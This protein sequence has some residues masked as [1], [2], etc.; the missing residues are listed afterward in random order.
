MTD[1]GIERDFSMQDFEKQQSQI[2]SR[3][4]SVNLGASPI[5][6]YFLPNGRTTD[7]I[8]ANK[9]LKM[10]GKGR[11]KKTLLHIISNAANQIVT[12]TV[13]KNGVDT[14]I[15][16]TV[17]STSSVDLEELDIL[18]FVKDDLISVEISAPIG[19]GA[20]NYNLSF[21]VEFDV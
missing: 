2:Q 17:P 7:S 13:R 5:L 20:I 10:T 14:N 1:L 6:S 11:V 19:S 8:E 4:I 9:Q 12:I 18:E 3:V 15:E 16:F 21:L